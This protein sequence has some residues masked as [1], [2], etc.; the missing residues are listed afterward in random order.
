M[1]AWKVYDGLGR[2][3]TTVFFTNDCDSRYVKY[4]LVHHDGYSRNISV[5]CVRK[6]I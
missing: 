1:R 2:M 3:L 6:G 5:I 4:T